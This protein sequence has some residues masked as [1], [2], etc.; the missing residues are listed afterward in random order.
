MSQRHKL[1]GKKP[2]DYLGHR[3][4]DA[5]RLDRTGPRDLGSVKI[6]GKRCP[7]YALSYDTGNDRVEVWFGYK[8]GDELV[9]ERGEFPPKRAKVGESTRVSLYLSPGQI[10]QL[11]PEVARIKGQRTQV[12]HREYDPAPDVELVRS[13][14]ECH[15]CFVRTRHVPPCDDETA[16][17]ADTRT[18]AI[19]CADDVDLELTNL[20]IMHPDCPRAGR[21]SE[22]R[23]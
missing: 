16:H 12:Y 23:R 15:C 21:R 9:T 8:Q 17:P 22:W 11:G 1:H 20:S 7:R 4:L 19:Q 6:D 18:I 2:W 14:K 3:W 5:H 13:C 10:D